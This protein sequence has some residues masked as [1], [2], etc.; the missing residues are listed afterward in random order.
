MGIHNAI[1]TLLEIAPV[2][3]NWLRDLYHLL[4]NLA[5][6]RVATPEKIDH[7]LARWSTLDDRTSDGKVN[8]GYV[9]SLPLKD[10]FRCLVAALYGRGHG[11]PRAK[12]VA[13]RCAYYG[14]GDITA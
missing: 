5:P 3:M 8:E 2:N 6:Q 13:L 14:K 9:T 7:V 4:D 10:E 1:F 12:D 11:S